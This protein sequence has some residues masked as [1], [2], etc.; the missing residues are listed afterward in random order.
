[1]PQASILIVED[2]KDVREVMCEIMTL[3]GYRVSLLSDG[4]EALRV[5]ENVKF[6]LII[7]DLGL[8]GIDGKKLVEK[9]RFGGIRTP[10]LV[11]TGMELEKENSDFRHAANCELIQKPFRLDDFNSKIDFLL[12][13]KS[14]NRLRP[15]T[16]ST[17]PYSGDTENRLHSE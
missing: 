17:L 12:K 13:N 2:E 1:M 8:P 4:A 14:E 6:D 3:F 5:I 7:T 16:H 11:V 15:N 10:I 9:I